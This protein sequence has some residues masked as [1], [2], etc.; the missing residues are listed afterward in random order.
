MIAGPFG[1]EALAEAHKHVAALA[2]EHARDQWLGALYAPPPARD[3]LMALASFDYEIR[4]APLR[5]RN[6]DL[7]AIRLAWWR[8]VVRGERDAEAAGSPVAL[9]IRSAIDTFGLPP[10]KLEAMLDARLQEIAP[11][12]D[13]NLVAFRAFADESDG[14]SEHLERGRGHHVAEQ[15]DEVC[16]RGVGIDHKCP[17]S[18][19]VEERLT[20]RDITLMQS[21]DVA[22][23]LCA[24]GGARSWP[25]LWHIPT[26]PIPAN[27][28]RATAGGAL[29]SF[30]RASEL[31]QRKERRSVAA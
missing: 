15:L 24:Y 13:F 16:V 27:A 29:R 7:A 22:R 2:R 17:L 25:A 14:F 9:A 21:D 26:M 18:E 11:Q 1:A 28:V 23:H 31:A 20:A 5:A 30:R 6:P 10:E 4:Q 3:A 12:D 19:T 8:D